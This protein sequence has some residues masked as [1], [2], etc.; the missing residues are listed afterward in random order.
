MYIDIIQISVGYNMINRRYPKKSS[1]KRLS[2]CGWTLQFPQ[3]V[4]Y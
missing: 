4:F 1:T 3:G 2:L